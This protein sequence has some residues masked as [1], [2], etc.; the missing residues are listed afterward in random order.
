MLMQLWKFNLLLLQNFVHLI[1]YIYIYIYKRK[2][3]LNK[4]ELRLANPTWTYFYKMYHNSMLM[5][6]WKFNL[7]LLQIYIYIYI[8]IFCVPIFGQTIP[9]LH[10]TYRKPHG[11]IMWWIWPKSSGQGSTDMDTG[12]GTTRK[13]R[14]FWKI[15]TKVRR[16]YIY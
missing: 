15:R 13:H 2:W 10:E 11:L 12:T 8:Y 16:G 3:C 5:Q 1:S 14:N 6:P 4:G 7:L 9:N